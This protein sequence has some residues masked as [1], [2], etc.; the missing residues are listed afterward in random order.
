[1][2]I[3]TGILFSA[4]VAVG[5]VGCAE[6]QQEE[7]AA[8]CVDPV[9]EV[10]LDDDACDS[11]DSEFMSN[12]IIWY[13]AFS[14]GRSIPA[15]GGHVTKSHFKTTKPKNVKVKSVPTKGYTYKA[16]TKDSSTKKSTSYKK[17]S[18]NYGGGM[19]RRRR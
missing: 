18:S 6:P 13:M 10:R 14:A 19:S 1:M 11:G 12:A 3:L 7:Y 2:K 8:V 5:L 15:V 16:P 9:S 4:L 17:K